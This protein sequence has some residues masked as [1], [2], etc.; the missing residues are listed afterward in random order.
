MSHGFLNHLKEKMKEE[1]RRAL[2]QESAEKKRPTLRRQEM[3]ESFTRT[4][5]KIYTSKTNVLIQ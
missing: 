5:Y 4:C 1:T 2:I 3:K